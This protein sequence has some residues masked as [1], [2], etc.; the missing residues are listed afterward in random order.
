MSPYFC[1]PDSTNAQTPLAPSKQ[2]KAAVRPHSIRTTH[3]PHSQTT[4]S[5]TH[6]TATASSSHYT[7]TTPHYRHLPIHHHPHPSITSTMA[8]EVSSHPQHLPQPATRPRALCGLNDFVRES[9]VLT[10]V[11]RV[12]RE[13]R[14]C[15]STTTALLSME[16]LNIDSATTA[17]LSSP[18]CASRP[19][20]TMVGFQ[21]PAASSTK[22][23]R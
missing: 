2:P 17:R 11:F 22:G 12:A 10:D 7:H 15:P 8:S 3:P 23:A 21:I 20:A 19:S 14:R 18:G 4:H 5:L 16:H 1:K 9:L 13:V 6:R